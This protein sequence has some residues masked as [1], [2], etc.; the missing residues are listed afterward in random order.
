MGMRQLTVI[1]LL[2]LGF[3]N[4]TIAT[5]ANDFLTGN[6]SIDSVGHSSC[7]SEEANHS[8]SSNTYHQCHFGHCSF[9]P[10]VNTGVQFTNLTLDHV[11]LDDNLKLDP[12]IL[13]LFRPPII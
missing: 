4:I 9:V 7:P 1:L 3:A 6:T 5:D 2:L 8:S 11:I 12:F 10:E 13:G